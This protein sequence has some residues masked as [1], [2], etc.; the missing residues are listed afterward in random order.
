MNNPALLTFTTLE[1]LNEI[2][3]RVN[4]SDPVQTQPAATS[5]PPPRP[6]RPGTQLAVW[7]DAEGCADA[8]F[9]DSIAAAAAIIGCTPS[10]VS[11][12]LPKN[13]V[14]A[15]GLLSNTLVKGYR[16]ARKSDWE[17]FMSAGVRTD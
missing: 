4:A 2:R 3:E 9:V 8:E 10:A 12:A 5:E 17:A 16:I 1:L 15:P 14:S 7:H 6:G 13:P 11:Q